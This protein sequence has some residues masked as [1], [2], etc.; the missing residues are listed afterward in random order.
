[1]MK[2]LRKTT[3][4]VLA[5][6]AFLLAATAGWADIYRYVDRNGVMHFTNTPTRPE[7][8]FFLK[9]RRGSLGGKRSIEELIEHY[10]HTFRLEKAL[11]KAVIKVES[12]YNPQAVSRKGALGIMQL[13]PSTAQEMKVNN[14][15]DPAEN[16]RGGTRYLR[17]MLDACNGNL[18]LALAAYNAG[19]GAV[20][21]YG[22]V[23]PYTETRRYVRRV[24][25]YLKQYR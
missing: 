21:Q 17:K 24:K 18:D 11:I 10:A 16:I 8:R 6:G 7:F 5:G 20:R 19:P 23:P 14:P 25:Q 15:L 4:T 13:I 22:G 3:V 1:M 9:E 2:I 12:D